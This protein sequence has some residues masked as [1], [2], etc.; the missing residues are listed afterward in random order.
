MYLNRIILHDITSGLQHLHENAIIFRDLKPSNVLLHTTID[1]R[2]NEPVRY[3]DNLNFKLYRSL[4]VY[5]QILVLQ[6]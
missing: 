1:P 3:I 2:T 4:I 6:K 5:Y